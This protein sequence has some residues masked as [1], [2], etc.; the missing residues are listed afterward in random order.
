[1]AKGIADSAVLS[2]LKGGL[3]SGASLKKLEEPEGMTVVGDGNTSLR[4]AGGPFW[5]SLFQIPLDQGNDAL[6]ECPRPLVE[7]L[8]GPIFE[9]HEVGSVAGVVG[10]EPT[11]VYG[12]PDE[13]LRWEAC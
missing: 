2:R 8:V 6:F 5:A 4:R 9:G 11:D 1:M 13:P 10:Y 7:P 12:P 3:A